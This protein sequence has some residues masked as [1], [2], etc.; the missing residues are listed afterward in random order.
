MIGSIFIGAVHDFVI[1]IVSIRNKGGTLPL[2]AEIYMGRFFKH[3]VNSFSALLLI[4]VATIFVV[5][6]ANLIKDLLGIED[7]KIIL[8]FLFTYYLLSTLLPIDKII[9]RIYPVF[10]VL[11]IISALALIIAVL[12][13]SKL[14]LPELSLKNIHPEG[15]P[16]Y[17]LLFLILSCGAI[18]GFHATQIP[19]VARTLQVQSHARPVFFGM[20]IIEGLIALIWAYATIV[21]LDNQTLYSL[22]KEGTPSLV[23]NKVVVS[24]LGVWM[25]TIAI[26]GVIIL[27]IT[28][29]DTAFRGLRIMLAEYLK[30]NQKPM[31]NRIA[32]ALPCFVI[33]F[34]L[35]FVD[36]QH[37]G[38]YFSWANQTIACISLWI[39]TI[40]LLKLGKPIFYTFYPALF[41]TSVSLIYILY[42]PIGLGLPLY[43]AKI[44]GI[45][46]CGA[47]F[48]I[49]LIY[50]KKFLQATSKSSSI[51]YIKSEETSL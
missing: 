14:P 47:I 25:G 19:I 8:L 38:Q 12:F 35:C 13:F 46:I 7:I 28:S 18:S 17:P 45:A 11:L 16:I 36:F 40:F 21:L 30:I 2:L 51:K 20:M 43:M 6:P 3:I 5:G 33:S 15:M 4:L 22:I 49:M 27:P 39:S 1:G 48:I 24:A 44:L 37:L 41:M 50:R 10:A 26:L 31:L 23:V 42:S 32:I 29:G 34:I 9:G